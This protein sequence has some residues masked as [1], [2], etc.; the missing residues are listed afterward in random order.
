MK[1]GVNVARMAGK[2]ATSAGG[3]IPK[4]EVNDSNHNKKS[5]E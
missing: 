2:A 4:R 5:Y 3:E 1:T